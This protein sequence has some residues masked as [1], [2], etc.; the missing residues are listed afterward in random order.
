LLAKIKVGQTDGNVEYIEEKAF[1]ENLSKKH[2][3]YIFEVQQEA[4]HWAMSVGRLHSYWQ[5]NGYIYIKVAKKGEDPFKYYTPTYY[6]SVLNTKAW[7]AGSKCDSGDGGC[8]GDCS[9]C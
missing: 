2:G 9:G 6:G 8:S 3:D 4:I 5:M 7:S 1:A